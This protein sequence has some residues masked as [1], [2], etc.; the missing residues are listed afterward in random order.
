[1]RACVRACVCVFAC[2]RSCV[3]RCCCCAG[4]ATAYVQ[5]HPEKSASVGIR[6][7]RQFLCSAKAEQESDALT[8]ADDAP[9][10]A[11]KRIRLSDPA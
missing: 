5:F 4:S 2:V 10:G 3:R 6:L 9:A 1:M 8:C 11:T 7:L